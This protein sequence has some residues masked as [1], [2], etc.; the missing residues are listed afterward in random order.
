MTEQMTSRERV[1]AALRGEEVD[2]TPVISPVSL[3]NVECMK[4]SKS[5]FP[6][7]SLNS[8]KIAALAE[9]SYT[10]L[11]FDSIMPYFGI[12]N[13][14]GA[15]GCD[16]SWGGPEYMS[17]IY[18]GVLGSLDEFKKPINYLD[19]KPIRAITNAI[20][21]L[22]KRY[23]DRVAM[24]GKVLGP[25]SLLFYLYGI[26]NTL[27]SLVL[28][29]ETVAEVLD[30]VKELCIE[31]ATAQIEAGAD[32]ITISEDAAGDLISRECYHRLIMKTE[33]DVFEAIQDDACVVFHLSCNVM[34][35]ADL[36]RDTG[37]HALSFDSR[38]DLPKLKE[39]VG[40]MKLIGGVNNPSTLLSGKTEDITREVFY[41]LQNG[42]ALVGPEC[43]IPL[44][45]PNKNLL[46]IRD[47]ALQ[48]DKMKR[49]R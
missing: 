43:A 21:L 40:D 1:L 20:A 29:P 14:A 30:S 2:R 5:Y 16:V 34:D 27:T 24:I 31:F 17:A 26:Q 46:T 37:Y 38:N 11:K 44:R 41:A 35:R 28:E 45:V 9:T 48:Y 25:L 22:K 49:Y 6:N 15:L 33:R 13:E 3:A 19:A 18:G 12:A 4:L 23:Q 32:V 36:I 47:A 39:M 10:I 42:V 7:A 8:V